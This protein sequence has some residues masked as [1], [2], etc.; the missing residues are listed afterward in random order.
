MRNVLSAANEVANVEH[1]FR[2][3]SFNKELELI[4]CLQSGRLVREEVEMGARAAEACRQAEFE[5]LPTLHPHH[6]A[7]GMVMV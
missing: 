2:F 4:K 5:T 7:V 3:K 6:K 1:P